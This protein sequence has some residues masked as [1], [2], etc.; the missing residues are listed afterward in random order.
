MIF[1]CSGLIS[2]WNERRQARR[3]QQAV[4]GDGGGDGYNSAASTASAI[5]GFC[6]DDIDLID[7]DNDDFVCAGD[8][9]FMVNHVGGD[10]K[11]MVSEIQRSS[12]LRILVGRMMS[13]TDDDER[14][15]INYKVAL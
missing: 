10:I 4:H 9:I 14:K 3:Q 7:H 5:D 8:N 11:E 1:C 12:L 13:S 6:E 2:L 15:R